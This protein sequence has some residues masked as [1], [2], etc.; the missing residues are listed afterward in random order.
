MQQN[1]NGIPPPNRLQCKRETHKKHVL[2][3]ATGCTMYT[4]APTQ[5]DK[6]QVSWWQKGGVA[7]VGDTDIYVGQ[8]L[9]G[10]EIQIDDREIQI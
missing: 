10:S 5:T 4:L 2:L 3:C 8:D 7:A 6:Q 9:Y 1:L